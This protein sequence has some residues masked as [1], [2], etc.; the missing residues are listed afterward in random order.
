ME[1]GCISGSCV[2]GNRLTS[3]SSPNRILHTFFFHLGDQYGSRS[4]F[5]FSW[6]AKQLE[7]YFSSIMHYWT[8]KLKVTPI[9]MY[10][11]K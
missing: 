5:V 1:K 8:F 10:V 9:C 4:K 2:G 3:Q 6:A 11:T 7:L